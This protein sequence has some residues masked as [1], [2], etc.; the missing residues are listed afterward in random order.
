VNQL[1]GS[2]DDLGTGQNLIPELWDQETGRIRIL[3]MWDKRPVNIVLMVNETTGETQEFKSKGE[4]EELLA[5]IR[6]MAGH[7]A[8]A[9]Y[10]I[11]TQGQTAAIADTTTG[12]PVLN[13][14]TGIPQ[15]FASPEMAQ[16]HLNALSEAAGMQV[17]EQYQVITRQAKKPYWTEMVYWQELDS[18]VTPY[19]DRDYPFVPYVSRR[20]SDDPESIMGIVRNLIDPQDE[21]NKRYS[22]LLAH[23]NSSSHSGWL[24]RKS[25]GANRAELE[26][27]GSKPGVVV[28]YSAAPPTQI[29]PVEMSQGH[30]N[31]LQA[32]ERNILRISSINAEMIGQ[33][34][35]QTV[36]GRAIKA[37][38]SGGATALRSRL[39]A[40]E[41]SS[42]DLAR[43]LF[44]RIQQFY[45][46][47][48]IKRIIEVQELS[49]P[50]GMMGNSVFSDPITG[51][52]VPEQM[53]FDY[54]S[55]VKNIEFDLVFHTQ[56][57][58]P[59]E[60]EAQYQQALQMATLVTQS[61]RP[62]GPA[63][64]NALIDMA[65]MP[66]KLSTALKI[67]AMAPPMN[68]ADPAGQSAT[69]NNSA[70]GGKPNGDGQSAGGGG[71]GSTEAKAQAAQGR[72]Q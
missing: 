22:N 47:E 29:H 30:F 11:V 70:G 43:M 59:T 10:Q 41:E 54:L 56:P 19:N 44:S 18:G 42:L 64:F 4:A 28:E 66:T 9:P 23:L 61:G 72:T 35:Q 33:T 58:T 20:L 16:S 34:T 12:Q 21:Y 3:T 39:K 15:E 60:R 48:K 69:I 36:S 51:M 32:S 45:T 49:Q 37:R 55:K 6:T 68:P 1:I 17:H 8:V 26:I 14:Q 7:D 31:L 67:D 13:P 57:F 46:P 27:M 53:I 38:Q 5:S 63:T 24:N 50:M 62:I 40:F 2:S 25:G 71:G 65:D 52:P